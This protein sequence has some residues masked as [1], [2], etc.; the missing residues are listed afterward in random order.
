MKNLNLDNGRKGKGKWAERF[1][2]L[3]DLQIEDIIDNEVKD[4]RTRFKLKKK[5]L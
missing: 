5:Y 2:G 3:N 4:R 1:K